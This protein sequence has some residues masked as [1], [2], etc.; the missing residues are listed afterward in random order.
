[1]VRTFIILRS[2]FF[3]LYFDLYLETALGVKLS[4]LDNKGKIY[5][6]NI[7]TV[8]KLINYRIGKPWMTSDFLCSLFGI[9]KK[10][11]EAL[12]PVHEFT[13]SIIEKRRKD[14]YSKNLDQEQSEVDD[15][16]NIYMRSRKK[17]YAMMDTLLFGQ[18][19]G[20]IDDDGIIEETDTFTFEGHDTTSAAM[21]FTLL[22]LAHHPE[23]QDKLF[24]EIQE[25]LNGRITNELTVD[26]FNQMHYMERVLKESLRIYPPVP[27]IG[28]KFSENV[29]IGN[30]IIFKNDNFLI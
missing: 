19:K 18:S 17:R 2:I 21:T 25:I 20:L 6:R 4:N 23:A 22:L 10:L 24:E 5:R 1:V 8:G 26:D 29:T 7:Y 9:M 14:F 12:K 27:Y 3:Y 15:S 16:E 13:M 30:E 28:R 11:N